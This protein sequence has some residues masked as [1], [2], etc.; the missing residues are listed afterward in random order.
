MTQTALQVV[1]NSK[2]KRIGL[3]RMVGRVE[4]FSSHIELCPDLIWFTTVRNIPE[5]FAISFVDNQGR[6]FAR[7]VDCFILHQQAVKPVTNGLAY[8]IISPLIIARRWVECV[9]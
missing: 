1:E 4:R 9:D 8:A 6:E 7:F 2:G 5:I 3:V